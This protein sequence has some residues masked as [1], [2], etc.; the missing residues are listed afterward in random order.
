MSEWIIMPSYKLDLACFTN[1][2]F[3]DPIGIERHREGYERFKDVI[4]AR[5]DLVSFAKEGLQQGIMIGVYAASLLSLI[6]YNGAD[7]DEICSIFDD[8]KKHLL[9]QEFLKKLNSPPEMF[10]RIK[11]ILPLCSDYLRYL[12]N[13]GFYE[14]W[15]EECL[16]NIENKCREFEE[17]AHKYPVVT[18]VNRLLGF[19]SVKRK[20]ITLYLCSFNAPYG[21]G[22]VNSFISDIR[23]KFEDTVAIAIHEMIHP[24]FS[25]DKIREISDY[26]W[27]D[28]FVREGKE[29]LS[30]ASGYHLPEEFIEE[31]FVEGA[32]IYLSEV[33]GVES[34]PLK[35]LLDHDNA[36]HVLSVILYDALKKGYR[37]KLN[38]IEEVVETLIADRSFKTGNIRAKY[39]QI[40]LDAGMGKLHPYQ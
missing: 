36:S 15:K 23:W 20:Q 13:N 27:Q 29:R 28:D 30:I 38:T 5:P 18:E 3:K 34:D 10:E 16:P 9:I 7:I 40:Y 35:Y 19:E 22:L 21:I 39:R 31:N 6:E 8:K 2:F 4:D 24:P 32:H 14:Y 25:R 26:L 17:S 37:E 11:T 33:M 12:H 1:L